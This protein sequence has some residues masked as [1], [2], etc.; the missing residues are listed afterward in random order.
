MEGLS[1]YETGLSFSIYLVNSIVGSIYM[2]KF[3]REKYQ[4]KIALPARAGLYFIVQSLIAV[5]TLR[6][7]Y[8]QCHKEAPVADICKHFSTH[9]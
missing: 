5:L 8:N 3:L 1:M 4:K 2:Q 7:F 9:K 6:Q